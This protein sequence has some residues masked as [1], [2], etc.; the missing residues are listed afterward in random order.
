VITNFDLSNAGTT[1]Q[2]QTWLDEGRLIGNLT[3]NGSGVATAGTI[4]LQPLN[5][6][7]LGAFN[8]T[9]GVTVQNS[10]F[11]T[12]NTVTISMSS[13]SA[14]IGGLFE[15]LGGTSST[16]NIS[17]NVAVQ[18]NG[19][20][21]G[22]GGLNL[23]ASAV[24]VGALGIITSL[25]GSTTVNAGTIANSGL[26]NATYGGTTGNVNLNTSN[27]TNNGNVTAMQGVIRAP[28]TVGR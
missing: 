22:T 11:G 5:Y 24:R 14:V 21:R 18:V 6:G 9:S 17:S 12:S 16:G 2:F 8:I 1:T 3:V 26:I 19:T 28:A 20:L 4:K 7:T 10:G 27:L 13:G 25:A 23:R 15:F